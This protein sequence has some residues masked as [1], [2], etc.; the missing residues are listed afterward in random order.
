LIGNLEERCRE[1]RKCDVEE[2]ILDQVEEGWDGNLEG[3]QGA[4]YDIFLDGIK[5]TSLCCVELEYAG[6][7]KLMNDVR[8]DDGEYA[9]L[10][11]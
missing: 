8:W 11:I 2:C 4:V 6:E 3:I 5:E 9:R 10:G 1:I 7:E